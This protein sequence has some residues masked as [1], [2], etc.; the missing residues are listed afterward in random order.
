[1]QNISTASTNH[2]P[3]IIIHTAL[4]TDSPIKGYN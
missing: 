1:L 3:C 4:E 2:Y